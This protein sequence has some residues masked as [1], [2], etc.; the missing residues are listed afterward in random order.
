L[1]YLFGALKGSG[2]TMNT[3]D[4]AAVAPVVTKKGP[5]KWAGYPKG[6]CKSC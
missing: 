5:N 1:F 4:I 2:N 3:D 6:S